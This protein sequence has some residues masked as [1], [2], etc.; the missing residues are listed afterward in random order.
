MENFSETDSEESI[1]NKSHFSL[2]WWPIFSAGW[3][4]LLWEIIVCNDKRRKLKVVFW[5]K[6]SNPLSN[7]KSYRNWFKNDIFLITSVSTTV[8]NDGK[9]SFYQHWGA[10]TS[11]ISCQLK[12]FFSRPGLVRTRNLL[13]NPLNCFDGYRYW[14][15]RDYGS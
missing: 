9:K 3:I 14:S 11:H 7:D 2:F 5:A 13:R 15:W 12:E 4:S 1:K 8:S 10:K 6:F